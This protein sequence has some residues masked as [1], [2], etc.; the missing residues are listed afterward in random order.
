MKILDPNPR[1]V[2]DRSCCFEYHSAASCFIL[3]IC[4]GPKF[5]FDGFRCLYQALLLWPNMSETFV[6]RVTAAQIYKNEWFRK[7]YTPAKFDKDASVNLDDID[8]V[9]NE[10]NVRSHPYVILTSV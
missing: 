2:S 5:S 10:S 7:G 9:F 6:Q 1:T 4:F 8:A 3:Q